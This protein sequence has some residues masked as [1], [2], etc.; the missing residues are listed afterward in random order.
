M[1]ACTHARVRTYLCYMYVCI[2]ARTLSLPAYWGLAPTLRAG[3][4]WSKLPLSATGCIGENRPAPR[5]SGRESAEW[6]MDDDWC[7][8]MYVCMYCL[9]MCIL[10]CEAANQHTHTHTNPQSKKIIFSHIFGDRIVQIVWS[11]THP[12]EA[13]DQV[14]HIHIHTGTFYVRNGI[15]HKSVVEVFAK[16]SC[17]AR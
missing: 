13:A 8:C 5:L 12:C 16:N 4:P 15:F 2:H 9:C 6:W 17:F 1:Y 3:C 11:Q 7:V 10:F 14:T